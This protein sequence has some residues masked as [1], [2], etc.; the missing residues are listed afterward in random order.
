[1][2]GS[3]QKGRYNDHVLRVAAYVLPRSAKSALR[4]VY[5]A[6]ERA[7]R[8][9]YPTVSALTGLFPK[10]ANKKLCE[11]VELWNSYWD[12]PEVESGIEREW[13]EVIWPLIREF[14]FTTVLELAPGAGRNTA[15]LAEVARVIYGVDLNQPVIDRLNKR[16]E[17]HAGPCR[18]NFHKNNGSRLSMIPSSSITAIYSWDSVVHFDRRVIDEYAGEFAR[19][20]KPGG[21]GFVHHSNLGDATAPH[22]NRG[23]VGD[24]MTRN[25]QCRSNMSKAL[26]RQ[27][28]E[29][30]GLTI[31]KQVDLPWPP[32]P[33]QH[34][35]RGE[36]IDCLSVFTKLS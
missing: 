8:G 30:R 25:P 36:V 28:C 34:L 10:W 26:F 11:N 1:M 6:V 33:W 17:S 15:K 18:L 9:T 23:S 7:R 3:L 14:D 2:S 21:R 31:V 27:Y 19:V 16:F 4:F 29:S 5:D 20:L 35:R 12:S 22:L 32:W 24:D 13:T